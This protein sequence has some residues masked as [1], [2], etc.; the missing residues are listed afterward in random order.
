MHL[1]P[2]G[3]H[4]HVLQC[5]L[6]WAVIKNLAR[7][8][9]F[10]TY[11]QVTILSTIGKSWVVR[12]IYPELLVTMNVDKLITFL[13]WTGEAVRNSDPGLNNP[14]QNHAILSWALRQCTAWMN[15]S[16]NWGPVTGQHNQPI[17]SKGDNVTSA[18]SKDI[19]RVLSAYEDRHCC[20]A[21]HPK[22]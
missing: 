18:S 14:V 4:L 19:Q 12:I 6:L 22:T 3:F 11:L 20:M 13:A 1:P 9:S 21:H 15:T 7:W 17:P 2:K 16:Q 5:C 8:L 10:F